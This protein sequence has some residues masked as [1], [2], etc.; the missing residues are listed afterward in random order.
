MAAASWCGITAPW[1]DLA[2]AEPRTVLAVRRDTLG[3]VSQFLRVVPRVP[4]LHIVAE[5]LTVRGTDPAEARE[6]PG[7]CCCA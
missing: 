3:Y 2:A 1:L 7:R 6:R 5:A 4:A